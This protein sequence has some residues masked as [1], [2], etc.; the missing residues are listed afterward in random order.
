[1]S[2]I[3][4]SVIDVQ[5]EANDQTFFP[6]RVSLATQAVTTTATLYGYSEFSSPS[7]PPKKYHTCTAS[8]TAV[9]TGTVYAPG[10][11]RDG[12]NCFGAEWLF[13]GA[14][15]F[16]GRGNRT[17]YYQHS[18]YAACPSNYNYIDG[19]FGFCW[20]ADP[21]TCPV[22]DFVPPFSFVQDFGEAYGGNAAGMLPVGETDTQTTRTIN[23]GYTQSPV[24]VATVG[25]GG[26][27]ENYPL[28]VFNN[29]LSAYA[30]LTVAMDYSL[31][32]SNEYT[33]AEALA[34]AQVLNSTGATAQY[35]PRTTGFVTII[36]TVHYKLNF[37][38]LIA[39]K[40]YVAQ[41]EFLDLISG[42]TTKTYN[43][44]ATGITQTLSDVI[45]QPPAGHSVTVR[46]PTV[47]F[48]S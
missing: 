37:S 9:Q 42:V 34:N 1:M 45:A 40:N 30:G 44:T 19:A 14:G 36:T 38:N 26:P 46:S 47:L 41:V 16:E 18:L 22:C 5:C 12:Q 25:S 3:Q 35:F 11:G 15:N 13:S 39:G 2:T 10:D 6:P 48:A 4:V 21:A 23:G 32:L 31:A 43:F 7:S 29:V 27:P 8:G 24:L 17:S 33:D 28:L 20:P